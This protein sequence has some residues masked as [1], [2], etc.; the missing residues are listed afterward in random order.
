MR[1]S[2]QSRADQRRRRQYAYDHSE[3]GRACRHRYNT[4]D[5]G[6]LAT[7]G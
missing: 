5:L 7:I 1:I 4:V 3:A 2:G 6:R